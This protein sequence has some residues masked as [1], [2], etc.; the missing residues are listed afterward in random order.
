M[1]RGKEPNVFCW[2]F[3]ELLLVSGPGSP[4]AK[5]SPIVARIFPSSEI[6]CESPR[7]SK[8]VG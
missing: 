6:N 5:P 1:I 2:S 4:A 8:A 3:P 7:S